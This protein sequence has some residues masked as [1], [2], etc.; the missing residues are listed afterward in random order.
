M[1]I[2]TKM[3]EHQNHQEGGINRILSKI[4]ILIIVIY[5]IVIF[6]INVI[7]V[8][9]KEV[10]GQSLELVYGYSYQKLWLLKDG[11]V[12]V[13]GYDLYYEICFERMINATIQ[14][15]LISASLYLLLSL[16]IKVNSKH[17]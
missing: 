14:V 12:Q 11:M 10:Y 17:L 4:R 2:K 3:Q 13:N 6:L 7:Y 5:I 16:V 9:V 15:T 1:Q 8:P